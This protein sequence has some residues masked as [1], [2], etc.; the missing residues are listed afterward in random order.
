M[1]QKLKTVIVDDDTFIVSMLK[2]LCSD[3][4]LVEVV[5]AYL[6]PREF[7]R[8]APMLD[9]DLVLLDVHMPQLDGTVLAQM[10]N[11][12]PVIFV[13]GSENRLK[14]VLN[15]SP[16]DVVVK[17]IVKERLCKA[18][19]KAAQLIILRKEYELF[20]VAES[21]KK[22]KIKLS[23]I[24][25]ITSDPGDSRNKRAIMRN[26]SKYTIMDYTLDQMLAVCPYLVQVNKAQLI[27]ME[28]FEEIDH[29]L[30]VMKPIP[31]LGSGIEVTLSR[32]YR[33]K[34]MEKVFYRK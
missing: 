13:T 1:T 8:D 23:D 10:L 7:L 28:A 32:S 19:E 20:N 14:D 33:Q 34:F 4:S 31:G 27:S 11:N 6:D 26:G 9:F 21:S 22:V 2:D 3:S 24:F 15:L 17:P 5:A 25:I 29:D 30:I 18:F 16:I 12:K